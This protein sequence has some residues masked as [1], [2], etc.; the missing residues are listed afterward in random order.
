MQTQELRRISFM[1]KIIVPSK[2]GI[3]G[4]RYV[5]G[6]LPTRDQLKVRGAIV[7]DIDFCC[8]LCFHDLENTNHLF[9]CY[10]LTKII[11]TKVG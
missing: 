7:D 4:W 3:F 2:V 8:V 11:W 5:L 9:G 1:W 10:P 6:R